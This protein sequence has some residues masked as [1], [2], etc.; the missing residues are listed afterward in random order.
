MSE[1]KIR[2]LSVNG[3]LE[4]AVERYRHDN[5]QLSFVAEFC[6]MQLRRSTELIALAVLVAH[7]EHPDFRTK[8]FIDKWNPEDLME[9]LSKLNPKAFPQA[10]E[11]YEQSPET[12]YVMLPRATNTVVRDLVGKVYITS[13]DR[14]HTGHLRAVLKKRNKDYS[15][16]FIRDSVT[17]LA[18]ALNNHILELPDGRWIRASLRAEEPGPVFCQWLNQPPPPQSAEPETPSLP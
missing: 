4:E 10:V 7:N 5:I 14:L 1:A 17:S 6:Y 8:K 11:F 18:K 9:E 12:V 13:C 3:Q 15:L 2:L 16:D